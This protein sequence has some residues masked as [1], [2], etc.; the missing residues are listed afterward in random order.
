MFASR[1]NHVHVPEQRIYIDSLQGPKAH[2][3]LFHLIGTG[4]TYQGEIILIVSSYKDL[5]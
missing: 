4:S 2:E 5:M 3:M 1:L